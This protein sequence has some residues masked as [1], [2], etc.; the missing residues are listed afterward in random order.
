MDAEVKLADSAADTVW[1]CI[2][3]AEE[4][5]VSVPGAFIASQHDRGI[6]EFLSGR[7][8]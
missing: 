6:A 5:L 7:R 4:I 2:G 3:H 1:A 8:R